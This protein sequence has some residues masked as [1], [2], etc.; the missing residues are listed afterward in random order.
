MAALLGEYDEQSWA[1]ALGFLAAEY[2]DAPTEVAGKVLACFGGM[3][4]LNDVVLYRDGDIAMDANERL[5]ALRHE[6]YSAS[7][8]VPGSVAGQGQ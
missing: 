5:D 4:S 1:S 6:V 8:K 2:D 3:G 7:R